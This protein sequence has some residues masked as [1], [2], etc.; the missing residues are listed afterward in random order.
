MDR[1]RQNGFTLVELLVVIAIIGILVALLLPAIQAAREASRRASCVN[2]EKNWTL[3]MQNFL[4]SKGTFPGAAYTFPGGARHG[5]PPQVWPYI[6]EDNIYSRYDYKKGYYQPPNALPLSDPG[7]RNAPSAVHTKLYSCPSD[8]GPAYYAW[9]GTGTLS[10]RA[11]YVINWGPFEYQPPP[12]PNFPPK[13]WAPFGF[14]NF[15]SAP[16]RLT[17]AKHFTDGMSKTML[18]SEYLMHPEDSAVDGR[19]DILNDV[20]DA[21]YMTVN[22][23]NSSVPDEEAFN[24]CVPAPKMP[25]HS[26]APTSINGRGTHNAAR[27]NHP[28]GVNVSNADGSVIF[29][30]DEIDINVW[31][32]MSTMNGDEVYNQSG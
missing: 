20:G 18:L 31:R 21:L 4:S 9:V 2:N 29:V 5:W 25:C 7:N 17:K 13:A 10:I 14:L 12:G 1:K 19:G 15:K 28:G 27:S 11:N 26:P 32:A 30:V 16:S 23:P 6:E 22:T 3:A 8:R 24:Y